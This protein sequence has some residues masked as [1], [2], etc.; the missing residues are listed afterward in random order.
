M[1]GKTSRQKINISFLSSS[2]S[3]RV[4]FDVSTQAHTVQFEI[5]TTH[6]C[7]CWLLMFSFSFHKSKVSVLN[8]LYFRFS[9]FFVQIHCSQTN[10]CIHCIKQIYEFFF[11]FLLFCFIVFKLYLNGLYNKLPSRIPA[12][13]FLITKYCVKQSTPITGPEGSRKLRLLDFLTTAQYG[14]RLSVLR[15]GRL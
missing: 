4:C 3:I 15:T 9:S 11:S 12:F 7:M 6:Q 14:G 2:N 13:F 1:T 8:F 10:K 5:T